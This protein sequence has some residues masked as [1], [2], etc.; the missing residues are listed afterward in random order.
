MVLLAI[1]T[2]LVLAAA[3]LVALRA[4]WLALAEV[5]DQ[6]RVLHVAVNGLEAGIAADI[7][8]ARESA[9]A[10]AIQGS[11]MIKAFL[12]LKDDTK[13]E[14]QLETAHRQAVLGRVMSAKALFAA[15][16]EESLQKV[17]N[18]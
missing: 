3:N 18:G 2:G 15:A 11:E 9:D 16:E 8:A 10:A 5:R 4:V 1:L 12:D 14:T 6:A 17:M 13:V 7:R